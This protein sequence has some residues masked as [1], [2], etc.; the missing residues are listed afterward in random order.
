M[1]MRCGEPVDKEKLLVQYCFLVNGSLLIAGAVVI[2]TSLI[3][4]PAHVG[5]PEPVE[6]ETKLTADDEPVE[7]KAISICSALTI[8][9]VIPVIS[10]HHII[11]PNSL[12]VFAVVC[13]FETGQL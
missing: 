2:Y 12:A 8:P 7:R 6:D 9:G 4:S 11:V 10:A 3:S 1:D 13:M 5:L